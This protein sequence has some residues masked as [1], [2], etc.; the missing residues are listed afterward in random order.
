MN[1]SI[2]DMEL[3]ETIWIYGNEILRVAGGWIY[4]QYEE[5]YVERNDSWQN[6][7][8]NSVFVPFHNEFQEVNK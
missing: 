2:Y 4:N 6:F 7:L 1:K 5:R 3:H 8:I